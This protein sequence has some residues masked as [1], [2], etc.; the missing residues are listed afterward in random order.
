[1][2]VLDHAIATIECRSHAV[3]DGGD[4]DIVVGSVLGVWADPNPRPPLLYVRGKYRSL[5]GGPGG[6][7]SS[8]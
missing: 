8:A 7:A 3:H 5:G 4:H 6:D 1:M 2:P